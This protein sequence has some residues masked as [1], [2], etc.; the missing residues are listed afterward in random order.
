[1]FDNMI[2][3]KKKRNFF[4]VIGNFILLTFLL[5]AILSWITYGH[6]EGVLGMLAYVFM[7][8]LNLYPWIVPF[9][10]IPLGIL[11]LFNIIIPNMH[12]LML[13]LVHLD[14]SWISL[15]WYWSTSIL[16]IIIDLLLS[17]KILSYFGLKNNKM[18]YNS[19]YAL[20]NCTI[21]D[22]N[23]NSIPMKDGVI[24][25]ENLVKEKEDQTPG[26][27]RAVGKGS[28][29]NIPK[30]YKKIDLKGKYVLPGLINAHCHLTGSGKPTFLMKLS[31]KW[32]NRIMNILNNPFGKHI[33]QNMMKKNAQNALNAGVTT[34]K[35]MS[36]P[37]F[38]DLQ[39]RDDIQEGK[40][41]GP[42]LLCA[43]KALCI[44]GGHAAAMAFITD[45]VPE[46]R[47]A[48]RR[49]LREKVDG[50]KLIST[51]GVMDAEKVGEAGRPQ[52]TVEEIETACFEA[53]R[54]N[55]LVATHCE[56][57]EGIK[58][59]LKGGVDSIE[60][61]AEIIDD[62]IPLF[63]NNPNSLRGF[64]YLVP[65]IS[66][67]M[68]LSTLPREVTKITEVKKKNGILIEKGMIRG[69]QKAYETGIRIGV[70]TDASVP[71]SLHYNVWKE[72]QYFIKYTNMGPQEAIYYG[73]KN[74]AELLGIDD[75]TGSIEEGK[76]ADLQVVDANPLEQIDALSN[77]LHVFIKGKFIEN[78]H[79]DEL[80][81][82]EKVRPLEM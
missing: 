26:K 57:T 35:T 25:I 15:G 17:N 39:V 47:K 44:T 6:L 21:I 12:N 33:L 55:L 27:I 45:S 80:K 77:V 8:V 75:I 78:P 49:N 14:P 3:G 82:L 37:F 51:G 42:R 66:A 18:E 19:N 72:L 13:S 53:H 50:I 54:G 36:D 40:Y 65:T 38:L 63:K 41:I 56:S 48:V 29:I 58:E 71:Y 81:G 10:G 32:L 59:A 76:Y 34:L 60:H 20:V 31:D 69:L 9:V 68:G 7:G 28:D 64:T 74:N 1:M 11:S 43:G 79:I 46:V 67:G 73:T 2:E 16:A 4:E 5:V 24:L 52:M 22:G 30:G 70:G 61:G 62:T 23:K